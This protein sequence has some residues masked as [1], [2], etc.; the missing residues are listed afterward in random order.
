M[1]RI[2]IKK[3]RKPR[4][5][6]VFDLEAATKRNCWLQKH[7]TQEFFICENLAVVFV[8]LSMVL[9]VELQLG[10]RASPGFPLLWYWKISTKGEIGL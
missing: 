10:R 1:A 3:K 7:Y 8:R 6:V 5:T 9:N 2:Q 4:P